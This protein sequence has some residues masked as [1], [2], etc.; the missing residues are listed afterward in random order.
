MTQDNASCYI[1]GDFV[2]F[3]DK[4]ALSAMFVYLGAGWWVIHDPNRGII[5]N[6]DFWSVPPE[7]LLL[8]AAAGSGVFIDHRGEDA[9]FEW[10][11]AKSALACT[12]DVYVD[13]PGNSGTYADDEGDG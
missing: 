6:N 13:H 10:T 9:G 4:K 5:F 7:R 8:N 2:V 3:V 11:P 1:P 12:D